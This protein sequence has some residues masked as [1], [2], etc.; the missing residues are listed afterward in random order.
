MTGV[1]SLYTHEGRRKY[2]TAG[3]RQRF[4]AVVNRQERQV[5]LFCQ[6]LLFTGCRISEAL[7]LRGEHISLEEGVIVI[8]SLKKRRSGAMRRVPVPAHLLEELV[9][10]TFGHRLFPWGRTRAWQT[11]K[12]VMCEAGIAEQ[13]AMPKVLR[14]TF[15]VHAIRSGVP[16]HLVQRWLGHARLSTTAIY[17]DVIGEEEREMARKMW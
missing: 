3:E 10:L 13:Q 2:L 7:A 9:G 11:V 17:L 16:V 5:R 4:I 12:Q 8:H 6:V 14:H 1:M 15:G